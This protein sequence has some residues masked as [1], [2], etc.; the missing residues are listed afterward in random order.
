MAKVTFYQQKRM[1]GGFRSG[2]S[3]DEETVL[4]LFEPGPKDTNPAL[5]WYVD[6]R[7]EGARLPTEPERARKWLLRHEDVIRA[8]FETRAREYSAGIDPDIYP[9]LWSD[10]ASAPNGVRMVIAFSAAR[11]VAALELSGVLQDIGSH[12]SCYI[13][14]LEPVEYAPR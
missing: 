6:P 12:W 7:C 3:V 13:R 2:I 14:A 4:G 1:D 11:R 8:G 9:Q 10:F 5:L